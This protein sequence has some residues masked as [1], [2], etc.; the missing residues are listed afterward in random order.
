MTD[1]RLERI[2]DAL[3]C[4]HKWAIE[5]EEH[6]E[7]M[8]ATAALQEL[9]AEHAAV[10]RDTRLYCLHGE[11]IGS[12]PHECELAATADDSAEIVRRHESRQAAA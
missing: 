4:W 11:P 9:R 3:D 12:C 2:A 10:E 7:L 8:A 1:P 5:R 6:E